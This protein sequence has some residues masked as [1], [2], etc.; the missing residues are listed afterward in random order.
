MKWVLDEKI[1]SEQ[2][3]SDIDKEVEAAVEEAVQFAEESPKPVSHKQKPAYSSQC[4]PIF[5][6]THL[7]FKL[8]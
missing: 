8:T 4:W 3:I 2:Q 6:A 1:L 5:A 7:L